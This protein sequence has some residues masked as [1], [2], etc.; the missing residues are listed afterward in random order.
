MLGL[1]YNS[2]MLIMMIYTGVHGKQ[3]YYFF[4]MMVLLKILPLL[5]LWH[6][7]IQ[8]W[9]NGFMTVLLLAI[10]LVWLFASHHIQR[11]HEII[12]G[13]YRFLQNRRRMERSG[14]RSY[15]LE[16]QS[17]ENKKDVMPAPGMQW[18]KDHGF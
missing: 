3:I 13:L 11:P 2:L 14:N 17:K 8:I 16:T 6:E 9:K 1:Y 12:L 4:I 15:F 18:L 10:F 7:P 5:T